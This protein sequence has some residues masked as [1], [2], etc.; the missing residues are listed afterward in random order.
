[1]R[2]ESKKIKNNKNKKPNKNLNQL[3]KAYLLVTEIVTNP[4][5]VFVSGSSI[6][7]NWIR[8]SN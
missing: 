3:R 6:N 7:K 1:M 2:I 8:N 4:T 5:Q